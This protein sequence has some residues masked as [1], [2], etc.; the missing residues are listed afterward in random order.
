MPPSSPPSQVDGWLLEFQSQSRPTVVFVQG[1]T[2]L[3][4]HQHLPMLGTVP[5]KHLQVFGGR[6]SGRCFTLHNSI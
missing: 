3:P 5:V 6:G 2:D 1:T 4:I